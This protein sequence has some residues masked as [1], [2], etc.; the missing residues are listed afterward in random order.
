M[1][2]HTNYS[3]G[4]FTPKEAVEYAIKMNLSAISITD[5]DSIDGIAEAIE[6]APQ[7]NIEVIPGVELSSEII[8]DSQ[9]SEMHILGYFIDYK[10]KK[11][12]EVL[13]VFK[14]ARLDRAVEIL[15][16]LKSSGAVLKDD[17]FI[18]SAGNKSIGRLHFAKAL[19]EEK[20]VGSIREAF[21]R[22]LANDKP[23]YV[24]KR[25]ISA[26]DAIKLILSVGGI[27]VMAHPYYVHYSDRNIFEFLVKNGL[28]GIEAWH[29]KHPENAVKKI[30]GIAG[31]FNLLVTGG[32]DCHGPYKKEKPVMGR[33]K[34]PYLVL[35][36][37]KKAKKSVEKLF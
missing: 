19:V 2:I 12:K 28:M 9:K 29:I 21:Q 18:R 36:N 1:H 4:V 17:S 31:E 6:A 34:V 33:I 37:L 27:P 7:A 16:K 32:S 22:Y 3:D 26:C 11:L 14:K 5:H 15:K 13:D 25:Y 20:L 23:A 8:S 35:E 24:S 10:S 30:L